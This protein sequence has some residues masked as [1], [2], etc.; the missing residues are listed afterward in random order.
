MKTPHSPPQ[1]PWQVV[2]LCAQWCDV[3]RQYRVV[4]SN[5]ATHLTQHGFVWLDIEERE[6]VVADLDIETF[7]TLLIAQGAHARFFGPLPPQAQP[8]VRLLQAL[9]QA[10]DDAAPAD[11]AAQDLWQRVLVADG[12]LPPHTLHAT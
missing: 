1:A 4:F 6:A 3:C 7:P 11:T 5:V 12:L 9:T 8:L 2:C 10:P